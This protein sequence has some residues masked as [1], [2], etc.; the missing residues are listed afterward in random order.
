MVADD[1]IHWIY[2]KIDRNCLNFRITFSSI[3]LSHFDLS[4]YLANVV[5]RHLLL[6]N[7]TFLWSHHPLHPAVINKC[8]V[9]IRMALNQC[10]L[11]VTLFEFSALAHNMR[12]TSMLVHF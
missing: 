7:N 4:V 10:Y 12:I 5:G 6:L 11:V 3:A 8:L 9:S 2:Y 1:G